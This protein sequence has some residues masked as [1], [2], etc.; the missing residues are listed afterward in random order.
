MEG[1]GGGLTEPNWERLVD[2]VQTAFREGRVAKEATWQPV[3][4]IPKGKRSTAA[5][6]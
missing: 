5:S 2:L 4:L 1:E 3:V 6:A